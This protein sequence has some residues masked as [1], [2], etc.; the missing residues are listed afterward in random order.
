MELA[1]EALKQ[2][3]IE[4]ADAAQ[5][6]DQARLIDKLHQRESEEIE[7]IDLALDRIAKGTYGIC[8]LCAKRIPIKRLTVLPATRFC[9]KCAKEYEQ[10]QNQR[11]HLRDEIVDDELLDEYR[12]LKDEEVSGARLKLPRDENL[13]DLEEV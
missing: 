9:R 8:Q 7:E 11:Q 2:R 6:E 13:I 1:R 4:L 12:S 5:K 10:T 3:A